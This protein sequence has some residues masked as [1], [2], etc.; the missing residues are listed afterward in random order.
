[1]AKVEYVIK[2]YKMNNL[3]Y[4]VENYLKKFNLGNFSI[5][6]KKLPPTAP[7]KDWQKNDEW[8]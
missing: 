6:I 2:V 5:F 4:K 8:A 3:V 7:L 1:M